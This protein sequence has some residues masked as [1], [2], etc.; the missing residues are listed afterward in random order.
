MKVADSTVAMAAYNVLTAMPSGTLRD[1]QYAALQLGMVCP[2]DQLVRSVMGLVTRRLVRELPNEVDPENGP[3]FQVLDTLRRKA[4]LR[5]RCACGILTA[6]C[7]RDHG[8]NGWL[9]QN[10]NGTFSR[11]EGKKNQ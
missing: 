5:D 7:M 8:W 2:S 4:R 3:R 10:S 1:V 9:V 6:R 11:L